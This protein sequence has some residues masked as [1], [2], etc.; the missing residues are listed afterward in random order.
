MPD[1]IRLYIRQT[2]LGFVIAA[3]FVGMLFWFDVAGLWRLVS[4]S[5]VGLLA[6]FLLVVFNGIVFSGVQF[7]IAVMNMAEDDPD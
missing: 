6:A 7:G 3:V 1:L 5:D 2:A 4:N